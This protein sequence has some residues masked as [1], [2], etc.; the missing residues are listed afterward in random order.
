MI[1]VGASFGAPIACRLAMDYPELVDGL[2]LV[3]PPLGPGRERMFW[4]TYLVESPLVTW[5]VPRMLVSA[6]REKVHH[7]EEL[8]K[9]L[10]LWPHIHVPVIYLQGAEDELV[11]TSNAAFARTHLVN[12]ASLDIRMIPGRGHLIAFKEKD[13]IAAAIREMLD[14]CIAKAQDPALAGNAR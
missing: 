7:Y 9:M 6:N 4:F 1:V 12:A 8:S 10:P 5:V 13:R 14:T 2:V 11:F 3:A